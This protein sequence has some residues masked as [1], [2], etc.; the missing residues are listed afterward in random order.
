MLTPTNYSA[1]SPAEQNANYTA[2]YRKFLDVPY[3]KVERISRKFELVSEDVYEVPELV[4][5][6][7]FEAL[8]DIPEVASE[9]ATA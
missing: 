3:E 6:L 2:S 4:R 1:L 5:D 9:F 8:R 7:V